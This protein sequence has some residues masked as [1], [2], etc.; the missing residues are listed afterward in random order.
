[1]QPADNQQPDTETWQQP[2][3]TG[4]YNPQ[5][6]TPTAA[7]NDSSV[8]L[9]ASPTTVQTP[10]TPALDT[11]T[12]PVVDDAKDTDILSWQASAGTSHQRPLLWYVVLGVVILALVLVAIL[13]LKSWSFAALIPVMAL[14]L[15]VYA[16]R[17]PQM[18]QY[19]LNNQ[20]IHINDHLSSYASFRA[21]VLTRAVNTNMIS[22]T[23]KKRFALA[24][25]IYFP[26]ELGEQIVDFLAARLPMNERKPDLIDRLIAKLRL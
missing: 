13:V 2:Q 14:A 4:E 3:S 19:V 9:Q 15:V 16:H 10:A 26:D 11:E 18:T 12:T 20:G 23:P 5:V 8:D 21:F 22:L 17:P 24:E 1:M 7:D 6:T 25:V